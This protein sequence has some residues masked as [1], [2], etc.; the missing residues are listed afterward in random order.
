MHG[1]AWFMVLALGVSVGLGA[2]KEDEPA[3]T[4]PPAAGHPTEEGPTPARETPEPSTVVAPVLGMATVIGADAP[5][6]NVAS[7]EPAA[8]ALSATGSSEPLRV[9]AG[10]PVGPI[11]GEVQP[12]VTF[13][14][15]VRALGDRGQGP[16]VAIVTPDVA[17][18]WAWLGSTTIRFEPTKPLPL[19]TAFTVKVLSGLR[20]KDGGTLAADHTYGFE[21]PRMH[22]LT[23]DP[24]NAWNSARWVRPDQT[25][26]VTFDQRPTAES[27]E[28]GVVF[29]GPSGDI[30]SQLVGMKALADDKGAD[31][32]DRR[33]EVQL[34]SGRA[35]D[36]GSAYR[37]VFTGVLRS[38]A[39]PLPPTEAPQWQ[40]NTYGAFSVAG[41]TCRTWYGECPV[42]PMT[43]TFSNPVTLGAL[44]KALSVEPPVELRWP[45]DEEAE[46]SEWTLYGAFTPASQYTVKVSGLSD[47]FGQQ[48]IAPFA[49]DYRTGNFEPFLTFM[50]GNVTVERSARPVLPI[51][52]VNAVG[53]DVGVLRMDPIAALPWIR[54]PYRDD[55]PP[56]IQYRPFFD[57]VR[58]P[59]ERRR[60][61]IELSGAGV[62]GSGSMAVVRVREPDGENGFRYQTTVASVTNLGTFI[63]MSPTNGAL[64]VWRLDDGAPV[65]DALVVLV[66]EKGIERARSTTGADGVAPLPGVAKLGLPEDDVRYG[67]PFLMARVRAGDDEALATLDD[68]WELGPYRF[69][70]DSAWEAEPPSAA[71]MVFTDRGIYRP[72]E[73]VFVKGILRERSLGAL[74]TPADR[75]VDVEVF[76]SQGETVARIAGRTSAFGGV[77]A[78]F[79]LP[80]G[81][82]LGSYSLTVQDASTDLSWTTSFRVAEF[83]AP[84]FLVEVSPLRDQRFAGEPV[85]AVIEG[86]YLFGA[87]MSGAGV[88]W[89]LSAARGTFTPEDDQGYVFGK[90]L[91]WWEEE[92]SGGEYIAGGEWT[93]DDAGRFEVKA[94]PADVP[95]DGPRTYTV[96]ASVTD[97]DRQVVAGRASFPVHP[98]AFYVG[99]RGP[100]GFAAEKKALDVSVVARDAIT[101][102]RVAAAKVSVKLVR[103]VYNRVKKRDATG[104]FEMVTEREDIEVGRCDVA[105]G[106]AA[107]GTCTLTPAEAGQHQIIAEATDA[108]G[109]KTLTSD[110]LWVLGEGYAAWLEDDDNRVEVITDKGLYD[111]G[112]TATLLVQSPFAEAEAW[113]T[114]E[115]EGVLWQKRMTLRGTATPIEVPVDASMIPNV[116]VGVVL[117]RGRVAPPGKAGDPGRP[118][119]RVGY[120]KL[121]VRDAAKRLAVELKPDAEEKKPGDDLSIALDVKD[122]AGKGAVAEVTVWAVD[123][124]VLSLTGYDAPD[125]LGS[126]YPERGLSVRQQTNLSHLV[127]QLD[128]GEKGRDSGGGG[129]E[130]GGE[131]L[132]VRRNFVTTPI[133]VGATVTGA[134]GKA[135]VRGKLPDN[136]T[137]FRL[138]AVAV[139]QDDLAGVGRA[140]VVVTKPLLARPALPRSTRAGD[141]FAAGVVVHGRGEE[142]LDI[143]VTAQVEGGIEALGEMRRTLTLP[144]RKGI[145]VRFPFAARTPGDATLTFTV[146]GG[147]HRDAVEAHVP[148]RVPTAVETMAVYGTTEDEVREAL[149]L[150]E[151]VRPDAGGVTFTLASSALAGLADD[152]EALIEYPYGCLEQRA[153]R[154][155]PLVVLKDLLQD[156]GERWLGERTPAA[157]VAENVKAIA[158]LQRPDGGFAYWPGA[159]YANYWASAYATLALSAVEDA[160]YAIEPVDLRAAKTWLRDAWDRPQGWSSRPPPPEAQAFGVFVLA[161]VG[162][163][164]PEL[165]RRLAGGAPQ[166]ALFGRALLAAAMARPGPTMAQANGL[167]AELLNHAKIEADAVHFAESDAETYAP[168][169]SSDTRTTGIALMALLATQPEHPFVPKIV[170]HLLEVRRGGGYRNTQ[171]AGFSLLAMADYR[172]VREA[173]EPK[174]TATVTLGDKAAAQAEFAGRSLSVKTVEL[175][176]SALGGDLAQRP[177]VFARKGEGRLYYGAR[178]QFAPAE[179]PTEARDDGIVVQRW[180]AP[181]TKEGRLESVTEGDLVRVNLR[182]ATNQERHWVVVEDPLP[183]GL[184]PVDTTLR[185]SPRRATDGQETEPEEESDDWSG[186]EAPWWYSPF[187]HADMRDD[188]VVLF[189]DELPP[190][191]HTYS[192]LAR[193]TTAGS[194]VRAPARAEEMY[195]PEV[196]GRS[197]GGRFWVH[198]RVAV[199]QQ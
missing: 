148:V 77:D 190:G 13:S 39:G 131:S 114:V 21:T 16:T 159:T 193:A 143:V 163:P 169:F 138:M 176:M 97:V 20:A 155:L 84:S 15:P 170:R 199:G 111:V 109:R 92:G 118:T 147:G 73:K 135:T 122:R 178:L 60:D 68:A 116:Y 67:V 69:G 45:D 86:R 133:F 90:H 117:E 186:D 56:G 184:E 70:A 79:D 4:T 115:R 189:A 82:R 152:A 127:A 192:Y 41:V 185:T 103:Q 158:A 94:G 7:A 78:A 1:R 14:A 18:R 140:K 52:S 54:Q 71:G 65:A 130:E 12:S 175:A 75:A 187:N 62:R 108:A 168:L 61:P 31:A 150:P 112:E 34:K 27:V 46:S 63:K 107:P 164:E 81:G 129:D 19:S 102:A 106:A 25:F 89:S 162:A 9:V 171:E 50:T 40:F 59:N 167:V 119:F 180:Y 95:D 113:V 146:E 22:P 30:P 91:P 96:E 26:T 36:V 177:L 28:R 166:M 44:K 191:L 173:V 161:R 160:G 74:R 188:R 93:L 87:A 104:A 105:V 136:L 48:Q 120:A 32:H 144:A 195:T 172:R 58:Q 33:V 165:E 38:A 153:S 154:L 6:P 76:D 149:Q 134:D 29:R 99:L 181:E 101:Q 49:G 182:I 128:F 132:S 10:L 156:H 196:S 83:R 139:T 37:M 98:A 23:G 100:T 88:Q 24:V 125:L 72:G 55:A 142:P 3:L 47:K 145:E 17:G 43:L 124:G 110:S 8:P 194:F 197:D 137:T 5:P 80:A 85:E 123:E 126:L 2:C 64:W 157:V 57:F 35:L 198:P 42:G 183:A 174:F 121:R 66:D 179:V 151:K 11:D 141:T 51:T 53:A